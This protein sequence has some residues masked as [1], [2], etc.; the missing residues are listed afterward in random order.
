[1]VAALRGRPLAAGLLAGSALLYRPDLIVAVVLGF[2]VI[3]GVL[4]VRQRK[5][6]LAGSALGLSPFLVQIALAGPGH[7]L[8]GMVIQPVF[9][10]RSGRRLP[11]PPS[12]S[13]FDG[14]LQRAGEL[15]ALGWP[16]SWPPRPSQLTLWLFALV[17]VAVFIAVMG[18]RAR[19]E[20]PRTLASSAV[21]VMG[22]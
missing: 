12:W 9:Q 1:M 3:W 14:F 6:L 17:A 13:H 16:I 5:R 7:A 11:L 19:R 4:E 15:N 21:L 8:F 2:A 18:W 10:L 22:A 20:G